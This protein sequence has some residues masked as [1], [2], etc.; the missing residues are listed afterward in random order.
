MDVLFEQGSP[1]LLFHLY[2]NVCGISMMQRSGRPKP[3]AISKKLA[4]QESPEPFPP[5]IRVLI[6]RRPKRTPPPKTERPW[7]FYVSFRAAFRPPCWL[8]FFDTQPLVGPR[9]ESDKGPRSAAIADDD[10]INV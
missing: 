5:G 1:R 8:A 2:L 3:F 6:C 4:F 7:G 9:V 10:S